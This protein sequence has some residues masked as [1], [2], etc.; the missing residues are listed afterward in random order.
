MWYTLERGGVQHLEPTRE[1]EALVHL[2]VIRS[3][4]ERPPIRHEF[5]EYDRRELAALLSRMCWG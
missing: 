1:V 4:R 2:G 3:A 5:D